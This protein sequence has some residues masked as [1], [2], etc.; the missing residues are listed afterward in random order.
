MTY[1]RKTTKIYKKYQ[2]RKDNIDIKEIPE[3]ALID[4]YYRCQNFNFDISNS[5]LYY[6]FGYWIEDVKSDVYMNIITYYPNFYLYP[7]YYN[8]IIKQNFLEI[9][10]CKYRKVWNNKKVDFDN[11]EMFEWKADK[12]IANIDNLY[13]L[14][15]FVK[16]FKDNIKDKK[17]KEDLEEILNYYI[18][19]WE[20]KGIEKTKWQLSAFRK[21]LDEE[22]KK[23]KEKKE[24]T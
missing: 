23:F 24:L 11:L 4:L 19:N 2:K 22:I 13:I 15:L 12:E 6:E 8:R 1:I 5:I 7:Q 20:T 18:E 3:K 14:D 17:N 16:Q 21:T 10:R 9:I